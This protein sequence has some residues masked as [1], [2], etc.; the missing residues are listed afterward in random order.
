VYSSRT[1]FIILAILV[2]ALTRLIPHAPNFTAIGALALFGGAYLSSRWLAVAV[3]VL[4]VFLSDMVIN[5][6]IYAQ[7]GQFV[8]MY[9]GAWL[10]YVSTALCAVL[11]MIM[12]RT[13]NTGKVVSASVLS[14]VLFYALTNF[15]AWAGSTMYAQTIDGLAASYIAALP[16]LGWTVLGN[17][18]FGGILFGG[19]ELAGRRFPKLALRK[20]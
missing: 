14:A 8:W 15:G 18:F 19:F 2:G 11:G 1:I 9:E 13:V 16:F 12:L 3:P 17:L 10:V 7:P 20:A 4:A 6:T 5:N